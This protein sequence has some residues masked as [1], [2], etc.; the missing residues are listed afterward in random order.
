M[1]ADRRD[2]RGYAGDSILV[3]LKTNHIYFVHSENPGDIPSTYLLALVK[4]VYSTPTEFDAAIPI[5]IA[6]MAAAWK[7]WGNREKRKEEVQAIIDSEQKSADELKDI[8]REKF[9]VDDSDETRFRVARIVWF[10]RRSIE[11]RGGRDAI[12]ISFWGPWYPHH[13]TGKYQFEGLVANDAF[14]AMVNTTSNG[15]AFKQISRTE[16]VKLKSLPTRGPLL[17]S[18]AVMFAKA[19]KDDA[20]L[21]PNPPNSDRRIKT[22]EKKSEEIDDVDAPRFPN[23]PTIT[24]PPSESTRRTSGRKKTVARKKSVLSDSEH[25]SVD[26]MSTESEPYKASEDSSGEQ[27][28]FKYYSNCCNSTNILYYY[29]CPKI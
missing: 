9:A 12:D 6:R 22:E 19:K 23:P 16:Q 28:C 5:H 1:V 10:E 27:E 25:D 14:V 15:S 18:A 13:I 21:F 8:W 26:A 20:P 29:R 3:E 17:K 11:A 24:P 7:A 4:E 2:E